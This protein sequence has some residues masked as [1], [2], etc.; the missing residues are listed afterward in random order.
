MGTTIARAHTA[1]P[2]LNKRLTALEAT[3]MRRLLVL[4]RRCGGERMQYV[5]IGIALL[6]GLALPGFA[7]ER[8][9]RYAA[10]D[11]A[12]TTCSS[13]SPCTVETCLSQSSAGDRCLLKNG[14]YFGDSQ[15]LTPGTGKAGTSANNRI[16]VEAEHDGKVLIN[17]EFQRRAARFNAGNN[18]FLIKGINFCCSNYPNSVFAFASGANNNRVER[19]IA[20]D[21]SG[22][23][24]GSPWETFGN[25]GNVF[26]DIAGFGRGR[27]AFGRI[28]DTNT[29]ILRGFF[30]K[31]HYEQN[32][33]GVCESDGGVGFT[34]AYKSRN[35]FVG[36]S[37]VTIDLTGNCP[38]V[39]NIFGT[40]HYSGAL[41]WGHVSNYVFGSIAYKMNAQSRGHSS[42]LFQDAVPGTIPDGTTVTTHS[43]NN[44]AM[45]RTNA[46]PQHGL[47]GYNL[48]NAALG[49][50]DP[51][52]AFQVR[53]NW[54]DSAGS[55]TDGSHETNS[56]TRTIE[57]FHNG[58]LQLDATSQPSTGAWIK[59]CYREDR[60][61]DTGC[62]VWPWKMN[63]RIK[64][65][66]IAS[67]WGTSAT[68]VDGEGGLDVTAH[69]M[70][71]TG[72]TLPAPPLSGPFYVDAT[73]GDDTRS[74]PTAMTIST[75]LATPQ[76]CVACLQAPGAT[77]LLRAGTYTGQLALHNTA[78]VGGS[79]WETANV[80]QAYE[81]T[82]GHPEAVV[83]AL[84]ASG[85]SPDLVRLDK[86]GMG[87]LILKNLELDAR[88]RA[89]SRAVV[90]LHVHHIR[91]DNL[92]V[93]HSDHE[94]VDLSGAGSA[95]HEIRGGEYHHA[96]REGLL[97]SQPTVT[98]VI[99][100][101]HV[102][103]IAQGCIVATTKDAPTETHTGL[104]VAGSRLHSCGAGGII[105]D[106]G[107]S[108]Q[109]QHNV[110]FDSAVGIH[111]KA[112]MA[113]VH[114]LHN[115]VT[116][117]GVGLQCDSGATDVVARDNVFAKNTAA[118]VVNNCRATLSHN[119]EPDPDLQEAMDHF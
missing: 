59:H 83:L 49:L 1:Q 77:C 75:P 8:E 30:M 19:S 56:G 110:I 29:V 64:D 102:H 51:R 104:R 10:P 33:S 86:S 34:Y 74:C 87:F 107:A 101:V 40:D 71:I 78:I 46:D 23:G 92:H 91:L 113:G 15:M 26:V 22:T 35:S 100:Q 57:Q 65:A 69:I 18:W 106:H 58:L 38:S 43:H 97:L 47:L 11:G 95:G 81:P 61:L 70:T 82:P 36:N 21:A 112:A 105:L 68:G 96:N 16:T 98:T 114:V 88:S 90:A 72:S 27:K 20:W 84:P 44:L 32:D 108:S 2:T 12:G 48:G 66:L 28:G 13:D 111:I 89:R 53:T 14:T 54:T 55:V 7:A 39:S 103:D 37:I 76:A 118:Q 25:T 3:I 5:V 80:I 24:A 116:K 109:V 4:P 79:S 17:G 99:D 9:D 67:G 94:L 115:T 60:T 52:R 85:G 63:A 45:R 6:L 62:N 119:R 50:N 41:N 117:N 31:N 42:V 73:G 93:H